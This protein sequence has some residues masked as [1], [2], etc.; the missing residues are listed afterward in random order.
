MSILSVN[1]PLENPL[2]NNSSVILAVEVYFN[3][4][5]VG[6]LVAL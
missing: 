3:S 2:G 1:Y 4:L 6:V 5:H